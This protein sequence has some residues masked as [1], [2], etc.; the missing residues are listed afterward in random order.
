MYT[1]ILAIL[2]LSTIVLQKDKLLN[3]RQGKF[4]SFN[5]AWCTTT[6]TRDYQIIVKYHNENFCIPIQVQSLRRKL[7]GKSIVGV[8]RW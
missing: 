3:K 1:Y 4:I 2:V 6:E 8:R 5:S 7:K